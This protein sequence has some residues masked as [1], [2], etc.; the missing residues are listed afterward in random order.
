MRP[1]MPSARRAWSRPIHCARVFEGLEKY[2]PFRP[3][4][5]RRGFNAT[6]ILM[7]FMLVLAAVLAGAI[8]GWAT[9]RLADDTAHSLALGV[10]AV[11]VADGGR[12]RQTAVVLGARNGSVAWI[13]SGITTGQQVIA[14]PPATVR[15][16][17]RVAARKP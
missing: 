13:R 16:G 11:F 8:M 3:L 10:A 15:D 12:A 4:I 17:L 5:S 1:F 6:R 7:R 2:T 9:P 14:Y